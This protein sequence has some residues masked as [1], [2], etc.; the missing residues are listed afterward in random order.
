MLKK[1]L[2]VFKYSF[3]LR[4]LIT[5]LVDRLRINKS[6]RKLDVCA[7]FALACTLFSAI[8]KL[9]RKFAEVLKQR[10]NIAL[11]G[12]SRDLE[13]FVACG[14]SSLGLLVSTEGD[15][16]IFKILLYSRAMASFI[17]LASETGWFIPVQEGEKRR[18][19]VE[20]VLSIISCVFI[21]YAYLWEVESVPKNVVNTIT[22]AVGLT[23]DEKRFF[24]SVRAVAE[25]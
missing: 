7:R 16:R 10:K 12:G 3:A 22:R 5:V 8:Y 4:L 11:F 25:L 24:D 2:N 20:T 17:E 9:V 13:L 18:V 1:L 21:C 23:N 6:I 15:Q 19:T 14:L